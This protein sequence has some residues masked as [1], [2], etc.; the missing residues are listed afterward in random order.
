LDTF[1]SFESK[2]Y[3]I[4]DASFEDIA[5]ELF[6]FQAVSNPVYAQY[7]QHLQRKVSEVKTIRDIPFLPISF[8]KTH[9]IQTGKWTP[10][11]VF[12][13]SGTTGANTSSHLVHSLGFY[14]HHALLNFEYFFGSPTDYHF[15]ALLPSYLERQDSSLI[16][17]MDHLLRR[18][19][20]PHSAYYLDN[21][22]AL[23]SALEDLRNDRRKVILWGVTFALLDLAEQGE[24]DLRHCLIF[25]TGGM[26]GRR[27]EITRGEL[28]ETLKRTF[29]VDRIYSEYGMTELFSQA[30][31][32]GE[33]RFKCPPWMKIM[34][35]DVTDPFTWGLLGETAGINVIDLANWASIS[36]IETEDIGKVYD[37]GTFEVLGRMDNSDIRGCN[38]MV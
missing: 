4:N 33:L 11:C 14:Q 6:Q 16:A 25:E 36:F 18:S 17:M 22:T 9:Q 15:L 13:S 37:D 32:Q 3:G 2:L 7:I 27:K 26:K 28:H 8:F 23:L 30:Y 12:S 38:L 5:L 31:T 21:T 34:G 24:R 1:K 20:S 35:R 29:H 10:E 19:Q